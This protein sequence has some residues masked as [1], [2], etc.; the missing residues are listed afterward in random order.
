VARRRLDA[1]L[2]RRGLAASPGDAAEAVRAGLVTVGGAPASTPG[3]LVETGDA[4]RVDAPRDAVSRGGA[5]LRAA[6]DRFV[7]EPAGL[8]CL[9]AGSSTGG[10]TECL[11]RAGASRVIAVDVGYGLLDWSLRRDPRVTVLERTNVRS[12]DAGR[13]PFVPEL[14]VADLSFVSL[15]SVVGDLARVGSADARFVLL[16]KP[17]FEVGRDAIDPG[18]VVRDPAAW[19]AAIAG[20]VEACAAAGLASIDVM[21]SPLVG[22]AGNVE[23]PLFASAGGGDAALDVDRALAEGEALRP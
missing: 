2:V 17:S 10:F 22:P 20:V 5:K 9:D 16:V 8:D 13:L 15:R 18:G 3:A 19:R 6:L 4:V 12:L 1:E 11:L 7:I 14:V 23:F 21:A